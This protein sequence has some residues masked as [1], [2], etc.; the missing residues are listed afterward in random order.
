MNRRQILETLALAKPELNQ[1][2]VKRLW[3][4]G[5]AAHDEAAPGSDVD[6]LVE[7]D[8]RPIGLFEMARLQR[9]L[10]ELLGVEHVD[11]VT[12]EGIH[13]ALRDRILDEALDAA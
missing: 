13:P 12:R 11:L 10:G 4:F 9:R 3:L 8:E 6:L 7:F 5:S 1:F 2:G